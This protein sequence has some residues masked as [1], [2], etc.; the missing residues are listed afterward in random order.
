MLRVATTHPLARGWMGLLLP[1]VIGSVSCESTDP[2][3]SGSTGGLTL[4]TSTAGIQ[5][6]DDGYTIMVDGTAHGTVGPNERQTVPGID[7]GSHAVELSNIEFNCATLGQFT[8][9]VSVASDTDAVVEYSVA[10]DAVSRS[11]IA[12]VRDQIF[13]QAEVMVMNAD[14][15][16][17]SSLK[18][19]LGA[20][21]PHGVL[22]P[23][24]SWSSD[25]NRVAFTRADGG[26]YATTGVGTEVVQLA[27]S[28]ASPLWSED[29]RK[30]AFLAAESGTELCCRDIFVAESDGSAVRQ[31]TD[32]LSLLDYDFAAN[33]N[34]LVYAEPNENYTRYALVVIHPDG[35]GRREIPTPGVCC[36]ELPK[37]SPDGSK[38]AYFAYPD[39]QGA[40]GP[41]YEIYVSPTDGSGAAIAVSN[42][43]GD[44]W[45]PVWSP[46]GT[47]IAF[48]STAAGASF[49]PGRLRVINADGT[50]QI[51]LSPAE[52]VWEPAWSPDGTRIAYSGSVG[53]VFVAN[54]DGS[55]RTEL[56]PNM[57]SSRPVWTGR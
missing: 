28:G 50:G 31:V 45:W 6:D 1:M 29:G 20:V 25:G 24:V 14:G 3:T 35:T 54:A 42:N 57:D 37:L 30:V 7:A 23:P 5:P 19:S 2:P 41:G 38:V 8:Q 12:F 48:G 16:D 49:G 51:D 40:N 4:V 21:Y 36:P 10:C 32:G 33:G 26:L 55:G 47:R 22:L 9:T 11:R 27:P 44:D 13:E 56:T 18:D 34:L 39:E 15:S 46:D 43:P 52:N 53:H 17:I